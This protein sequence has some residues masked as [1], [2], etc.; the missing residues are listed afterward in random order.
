MSVHFQRA[1]QLDCEI[2]REKAACS[3]MTELVEELCVFVVTQ[4]HLPLVLR[5]KRSPETFPLQDFDLL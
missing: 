2:T 5:I 1:D 4:R 3:A